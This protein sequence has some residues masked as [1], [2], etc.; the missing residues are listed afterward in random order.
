V[1]RLDGRAMT[2]ARRLGAAGRT[3]TGRLRSH[4]EDRLLCD[5]SLG[6]YAVID[7]VGGAVAGETGAREAAAVLE[8]RLGRRQEGTVEQQVREAVALANNRIFELGSDDARLRGMACVLT[9]AVVDG[10]RA[11]VGHVGDTRLYRIARGSIEKLTRD[12]S[13][14]GELED[15]GEISELEAMR[16]P[17]R[18]EIYRDV[19]TAFHRP[20]D[21]GFVDVFEVP[22]GAEDALLMC[23][24]GLSDQVRAADIL[25]VVEE[26]AGSP[27]EAA[28]RLVALANEAGGKDNVSVVIVEGE[29]FGRRRPV[30]VS[31][32]AEP[33]E[34]TRRLRAV[35]A[36]AAA[37]AARPESEP[38]PSPPATPLRGAGR[39][40]GA[41]GLALPRARWLVAAALIVALGS[42]AVLRRDDLPRWRSFLP[43][44]ARVLRVGPSSGFATIA[45]A[46]DAARWGHVV[47]VEPGTYDERIELE[48]GVTLRSRVPGAAVLRPT[49][50]GSLE[51]MV[52]VRAVGVKGARLEGFR[53]AGAEDGSLDVGLLLID[54]TVE[55]E[56]VEI[57]GAVAAGV[58][59]GGGDRSSLLYSHLHEN[60]GRAI[61][62]ESAAAPKIVHNLVRANGRPGAAGASALEVSGEGS[63][64]VVGNRFLENAG[65]AVRVP[66]RVIADAIAAQNTFE[67]DDADRT[68]E[69]VL[70]G[71]DS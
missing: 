8:A 45:A 2:P 33:G 53:I 11:V 40:R 19:G 36:G 26:H 64:I 9:V 42:L 31:R 57:H 7:G 71:G 65:L 39:I 29:R 23:S 13:P 14:V 6:I 21:E 61:L 50:E 3:D 56:N 16:H 17:R 20:D 69:A 1:G 46:L 30:A 62:V 28:E 37:G 4:N 51:E 48:D 32:R 47:E 54:S 15:A 66:T 55:A 5:P 25:R 60:P 18:N 41:R 49:R 59:F 38:R 68:V 10:E 27:R 44:Q 34:T 70:G 24:D 43:A 52:A 35:T 67:P 22:F 58:R 12:H 63:P